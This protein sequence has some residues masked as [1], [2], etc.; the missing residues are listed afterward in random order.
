[1][2][3]SEFSV[4]GGLSAALPA[5]IQNVCTGHHIARSGD[6]SYDNGLC[7]YA[8]DV[9][10]GPTRW[11]F[12]QYQ[13]NYFKIRNQKYDNWVIANS[14]GEI[15]AHNG[16]DYPDQYWSIERAPGRPGAVRL[17]NRM[18]GVYL[19]DPNPPGRTGAL[20]AGPV[21]AGEEA[22]WDWRLLG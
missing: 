10:G 11:F 3:L 16:S 9:I 7:A 20:G 19:Y 18:Y 1:M 2:A 6:W 13:E 14:G 4:T 5:M 12:L 21:K 8:G 17:L 15:L 22:R